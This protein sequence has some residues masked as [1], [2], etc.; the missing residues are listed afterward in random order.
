M[1][2]VELEKLNSGRLLRDAGQ[3]LLPLLQEMKEAC[4]A[5]TVNAHR[6][7]YAEGKE[8]LIAC[9]AELS[10]IEQLRTK[11]NRNNQETARRE[12]TFNAEPT[13]T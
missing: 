1:T 2:E 11:I 7:M 6:S 3:H 4:L 13:V 9:A 12:E 10:V 8:V 5:R